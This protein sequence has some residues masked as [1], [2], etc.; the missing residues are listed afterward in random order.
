MKIFNQYL[1]VPENF[2]GICK[3]YDESVRHFKERYYHREDGPA[4]E[5]KS[6]DKYWYYKNKMYGINNDFTNESWIEFAENLKRQEELQ[7]FK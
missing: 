3:F 7:I 4:I 1:D 5:F 6:G 2:T